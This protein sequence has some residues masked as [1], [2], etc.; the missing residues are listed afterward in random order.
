LV[1]RLSL[2]SEDLPGHCSLFT[3]IAEVH[4]LGGRL[5]LTRC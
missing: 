1:R 2:P 3:I 5:L 4:R